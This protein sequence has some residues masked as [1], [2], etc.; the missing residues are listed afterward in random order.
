MSLPSSPVTPVSSTNYGIALGILSLKIANILYASILGMRTVSH[1]PVIT[2]PIGSLLSIWT[3]GAIYVHYSLDK[4]GKRS[5]NSS[6][7]PIPQ[8][9]PSVILRHPKKSSCLHSCCIK[10]P[11]IC[12]DAFVSAIL[13][14]AKMLTFPLVILL[15]LLPYWAFFPTQSESVIPYLLE[16]TLKF[17]PYFSGLIWLEYRL[18]EALSTWPKVESQ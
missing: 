4:I 6:S 7:S 14:S 5:I 8:C 13:I 17:Y 2:L 9:P 15:G 3:V 18:L 1:S 12:L 11:S 16:T 10:A